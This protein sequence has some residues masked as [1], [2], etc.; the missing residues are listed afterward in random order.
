MECFYWNTMYKDVAEYMNNCPHCQVAK[1]YYVGLKTK[2]V[3][4][5]LLYINFM[6]MALQETLRKMYLS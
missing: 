3:S 2:L 4:L 5:D 1:G 6:K